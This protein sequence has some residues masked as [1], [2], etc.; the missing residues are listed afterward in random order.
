MPRAAG[1]ASLWRAGA[2][3]TQ[4]FILADSAMRYL[5]PLAGVVDVARTCHVPPLRD[6]TC[7]L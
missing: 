3:G 5:P 6:Q 4:R 1:N 7:R 2:I